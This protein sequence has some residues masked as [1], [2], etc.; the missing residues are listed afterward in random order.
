M[1]KIILMMTAICL[2]LAVYLPFGLG[3]SVPI[4]DTLRYGDTGEAVS[5][6]QTRLR[7]LYYYTGPVSGEYGSMTQ[8]AVAAVQTAYGMEPTGV[9]DAETLD[10]IYGECY[11]PLKYNDQGEDVKSLQQKLAELGYYTGP[12][13][14]KYLDKTAASPTCSLWKR[15]T[16][17]TPGPR[18]RP[19]PCPL[20]ISRSSTTVSSNT[21]PPV[22]ASAWCS[23][24]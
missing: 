14:G 21:A 5:Q 19:S 8:T 11:R 6:L 12:V 9:A 1:K 10:L 4:D 7:A 17:P 2:I 23:S 15:S 13:S 24:A 18:P 22:N 16:R 20:P 3:E